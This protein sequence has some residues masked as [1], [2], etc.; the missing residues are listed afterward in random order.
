MSRSTDVRGL[1]RAT[2]H[3]FALGALVACATVG[4]APAD[5]TQYPGVGRPATP[6][7]I[8][9]W[10]IDVRPDFQGLPPGSGSVA[11]GQKI[12]DGK[13]AMCHGDFGDSNEVFTPL[14]G[15]TT[16]E[17]IKAGRVAS[18]RNP[19]QVRTTLMKVSTVST[20]WDYI[21]RAMPWN[22]PKSL[23][24]NDVYAVLAYL[25]NLGA[26]VP[27]DYVL[28]DRN[29][30]DVQQK[31][32][33]RNGMMRMPGLWDV[34]GTPDVAN[35]ACMHDCP[36]RGAVI[37]SLPGA[38]RGSHGDLADQN[39]TYG[40]VR[41]QGVP[42]VA[43]AAK[44][45]DGAGGNDAKMTAL[46]DRSGCLV[47]HG[48][49]SK[50]VGPGY[51]D[52]AAKYHGDPAAQARLEAKVKAGGAGAWGAVPMPAQTQLSDADVHALV[53]WILGSTN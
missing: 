4:A 31:M 39:R 43:A 16:Q 53:Q 20:L 10:D 3:A 42:T 15:G 34:H 46:A 33:N 17:D 50:I 51:S 28:S 2:R 21:R 8:K 47:C 36:V 5:A 25:L 49:T 9:A 35:V 44:P 27:D 37:S 23:S 19:E 22:A 13:C 40:P 6:A 26:I 1:V 52:V 45:G 29:I 14:A 38:A 7:E 48:L 11:D 24:T 32:P 41:G 18:L 12:W 30:A